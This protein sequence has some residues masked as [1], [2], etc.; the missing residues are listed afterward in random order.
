[1][2][3]VDMQDHDKRFQI[4]LVKESLGDFTQLDSSRT[5]FLDR[6]SLS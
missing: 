5:L 3:R 2:H 6:L 4:V 1:M